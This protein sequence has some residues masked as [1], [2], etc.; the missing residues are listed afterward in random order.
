MQGVGYKV[1]GAGYKVYGTGY[2]ASRRR[3]G[4]YNGPYTDCRLG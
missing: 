4:F 3:H 1:Y 2:K